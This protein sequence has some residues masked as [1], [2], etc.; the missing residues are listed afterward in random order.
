MAAGT[1]IGATVDSDIS[2]GCGTLITAPGVWY[3]FESDLDCMSASTCGA[4]PGVTDYDSQISVYVGSDSENLQCVDGNDDGCGLQSFTGQ[5]PATAMT[6]YYV[7]VHGFGE[8]AG[9]FTLVLSESSG[10]GI[11]CTSGR[12]SGSFG[13]LCF[14]FFLQLNL[15]FL[16]L[17]LHLHAN[18]EKSK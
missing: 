10:C 13:S 7:L 16:L 6:Q 8:G 11:V 5:F 3:T 17:F 12:T 1:T 18:V 14:F 4:T 9:D 2:N 15:P